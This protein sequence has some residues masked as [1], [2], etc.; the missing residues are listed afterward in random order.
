MSTRLPFSLIF[1]FFFAVAGA[2]SLYFPPLTGV[3]WSTVTPAELGWQEA[4]LAET[5]QWLDEKNSKAFIILQDGKIAVEHY[6]G[7]FTRDSLWYWASAGK[8][9][10]GTMVG[11][12]QEDGLLDIDDVSA[13]YLGQGWTEC[14]P[15]KEALIT[16][17]H[18][19]SMSTGLDDSLESPGSTTSCF[20]PACF[21]Y[22]ADAGTR[23]AYHNGPYRIVEDMLATVSGKTY[24]QYTRQRLGNR[25][26]MGGFWYNYIYVSTA[27]DM[28]RFGL[29]TLNRGQWANDRVMQDTAYFEAMTNTSQNLNKSYGYLWWLNG[30][31]S[32]MLPGLQTVFN[33]PLVPNAPADM[34]AAMGKNEQR[35][36]VIPS[37]NRVVVR[38]GESAFD[39]APA[40]SIFDNQL[41]ERLS[42]VFTQT[43]AV[44]TPAD[45]S[46]KA[47]PNPGDE[48]LNLEANTPIER[49]RVWN[50]LGSLILD[51]EG[52]CLAKVSLDAGAWP[53]GMYWVEA[54]T[55]GGRRVV[56]WVV[57]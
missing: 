12:A 30:K 14:P 41:W 33:G 21:Q 55:D 39:G 28:A 32:F 6:F 47:W 22:K 49:V 50:S 11:L 29:L 48:T 25:I 45:T 37:Q 19:I 52:M 3:Q 20:D 36:Y 57:R 31:A 9:L 5:L 10:T 2:Q 16:V 44:E 38:I 34:F 17:R 4:A 8:S 24:T 54:M 56:K 40:L 23:W 46:F 35:I 42:Q 53:A 15:D 18:H 27:R 26:G 7:A 13:D 1:T 51:Q 43:T